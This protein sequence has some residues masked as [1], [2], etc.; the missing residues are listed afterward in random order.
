MSIFIQSFCT[1]R[2]FQALSTGQDDFIAATMQIPGF[3][4]INEI[5]P[6][7]TWNILW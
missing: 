2:P 4:D 3:F 6:N 5:A 7:Y 1:S